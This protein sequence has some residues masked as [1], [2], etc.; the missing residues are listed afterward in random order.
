MELNFT[1]IV[2]TCT[3]LALFAANKRGVLV[4]PA[5]IFV[6]LPGDL[7]ANALIILSG[8]Y[9]VHDVCEL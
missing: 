7:M 1:E 3:F 6:W 8:I 9:N 4:V 5:N 2:I